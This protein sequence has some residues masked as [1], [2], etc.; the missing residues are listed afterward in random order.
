MTVRQ[1]PRLPAASLAPPAMA[2][3]LS[4]SGQKGAHLMPRTSPFFSVNE[5]KKTAD[6]RVH[7]NNSA[8]PPGRDIPRNEPR[9]L[10][11]LPGLQPGQIIVCKFTNR[12]WAYCGPLPGDNIAVYDPARATPKVSVFRKD[13]FVQ[14][15]HG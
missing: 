11:L 8:C 3:Y 14:V 13:I 1:S 4:P 5:D 6:K 2:C 10:A 15:E 12:K 9:G 7:H